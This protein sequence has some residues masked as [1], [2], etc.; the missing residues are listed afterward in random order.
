MLLSQLHQVLELWDEF[1][2]CHEEWFLLHQNHHSFEDVNNTR[3]KCYKVVIDLVV[4]S[5]GGIPKDVVLFLENI[6]FIPIILESLMKVIKLI[7]C[8]IIGDG[9]WHADTYKC[10]LVYYIRNDPNEHFINE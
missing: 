3:K 10:E 4:T 2:S 6:V 8:E 1:I 5:W 9:N 7:M